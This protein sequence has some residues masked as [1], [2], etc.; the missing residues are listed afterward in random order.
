MGQSTQRRQQA[1]RSLSSARRSSVC[2]MMLHLHRRPLIVAPCA[3][4]C[5]VLCCAM[6]CY[7]SFSTC[8]A[9]AS[10]LRVHV[11]DTSSQQQKAHAMQR[12]VCTTSDPPM[13]RSDSDEHGRADRWMDERADERTDERRADVGAVCASGGRTGGMLLGLRSVG[14]HP[15]HP[16]VDHRPP[17]SRRCMELR[18]R[19]DNRRPDARSL[20]SHNARS[21]GDFDPSRL[22]PRRRVADAFPLL[23]SFFLSARWLA[24][25]FVQ[26]T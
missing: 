3:S 22:H 18:L 4:Q 12:A 24:F 20:S 19:C 5:A 16:L 10:S 23:P 1:G 17:Q 6:L 8:T 21:T 7:A 14:L 9:L 13:E 11:S 2:L 15:N 25:F 26:S